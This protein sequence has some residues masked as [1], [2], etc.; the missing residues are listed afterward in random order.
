M[1]FDPERHAT[2]PPRRPKDRTLTARDVARFPEFYIAGPGRD[3][4]GWTDCGHGYNL[5]DSCPSCPDH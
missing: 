2:P 3:E 4:G 1:T 5:P